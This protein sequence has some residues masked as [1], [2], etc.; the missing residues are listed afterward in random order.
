MK[1][2]EAKII[3]GEIEKRSLVQVKASLG[4]A[5]EGRRFGD[6]SEYVQRCQKYPLK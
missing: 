1:E 3:G 4:Q 2:M 6:I 5:I